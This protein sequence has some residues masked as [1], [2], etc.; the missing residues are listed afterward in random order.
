VTCAKNAN[1]Q[2]EP[3]DDAL[4]TNLVEIA[5][6]HFGYAAGAQ[7]V[8]KGVDLRVEAGTTLGLNVD[9]VSHDKRHLTSLSDRIESRNVTLHYHDVPDR[10]P[11]DLV[12]RMF[13]CDL[14]AMGIKGGHRCTHE[15][16]VEAP[17]TVSEL[18][19]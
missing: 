3:T 2:N 12:Y 10:M 19:V 15:H 4:M 17:R 16:V 5:N 14:E 7:T 13:A 11:A 9:Y 1:S 6:L 18:R 8:L